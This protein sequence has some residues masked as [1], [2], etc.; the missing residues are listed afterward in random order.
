MKLFTCVKCN[1][2]FNLGFEYRECTGG[3]GG[4][5]YTDRINAQIWGDRETVFVVGFA[6]ST[7]VDALR[8]QIKDGDLESMMPYAGGYVRQGRPF[9]AFIIPESAPSVKHVEQKFDPIVVEKCV[10]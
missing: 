8:A 1:E 9:T 10:D 2:I 5:Q 7:F 3:H 6:N 4:G